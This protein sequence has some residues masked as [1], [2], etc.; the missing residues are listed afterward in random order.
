M[1]IEQPYRERPSTW[2]WPCVPCQEA[3]SSPDGA[4]CGT[5]GLLWMRPHYEVERL[6][7][8]GAPRR[9]PTPR[10]FGVRPWINLLWLLLLPIIA[11]NC[12]GVWCYASMLTDPRGFGVDIFCPLG[13]AACLASAL[14]CT[15]L[16]VYGLASVCRPSRLEAFDAF[17]RVRVRTGREDR[18]LGRW[19]RTDLA[20]PYEQIVG[21]ARTESGSLCVLHPSGSA[22]V[23]DWDL[24]AETVRDLAAWLSPPTA[25]SS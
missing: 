20:V 4:V 17:L 23:I 1:T 15:A 7:L 18:V 19:R 22:W 5:C 10:A 24:R 13:I 2:A 11:I 9:R 8:N 25:P 12:M 14:P 21:V 3:W 6:L 16:V